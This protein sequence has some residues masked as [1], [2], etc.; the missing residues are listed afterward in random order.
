MLTSLSL[1]PSPAVGTADAGAYFNNKVLG[2]VDYGVRGL[3]FGFD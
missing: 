3:V 1:T 2:A